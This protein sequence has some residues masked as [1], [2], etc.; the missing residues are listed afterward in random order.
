MPLE[1]QQVPVS[2]E[3]RTALQN[4]LKLAP[5]QHCC[6][7]AVQ[8]LQLP[9]GQ[10]QQLLAALPGSYTLKCCVHLA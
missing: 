3:S 2:L 4:L 1:Y 6:C 9:E 10:Q 7:L 5:V 8:Q